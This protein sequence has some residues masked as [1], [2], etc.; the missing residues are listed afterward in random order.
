MA[1]YFRNNVFFLERRGSLEHYVANPDLDLCIAT[2]TF[3][4]YFRILLREVCRT[5]TFYFYPF[6]VLSIVF[7]VQSLTSKKV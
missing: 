1:Y 5:V 6:R 2:A 3:R 4:L 7:L